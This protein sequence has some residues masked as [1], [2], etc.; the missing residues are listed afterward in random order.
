[1][2]DLLN[3]LDGNHPLVF[4]V[5]T[6]ATACA[7]GIHYANLRRTRH[8]DMASALVRFLDEPGNKDLFEKAEMV[9]H[10][11]PWAVLDDPSVRDTAGRT[12][13]ALCKIARIVTAYS[14]WHVVLE[15]AQAQTLASFLVQVAP[16]VSVVRHTDL[17]LDGKARFY[18]GNKSKAAAELYVIINVPDPDRVRSASIN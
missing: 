18:N 12:L 10:S 11:R 2:F 1:M 8:Q 7:T 16:L 14:A 17:T 5:S 4:G 13:T 9:V 3:I 15:G 6:I